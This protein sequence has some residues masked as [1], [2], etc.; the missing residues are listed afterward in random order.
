MGQ[1]PARPRHGDC[2]AARRPLVATDVAA[3]ARRRQLTHVI[4][5]DVPSAPAAY[6]HRIG[7]VGRA[8]REGVAI[9]LAQPREHRM[10]KQIERATKQPIAVEKVPTVADLRSRRLEL[11]R[12]GLEESLL[13]DELDHFRVVVETLAEEHDVMDIAAAA[14]KLAHELAA[15]R[16]TRTRSPTCRRP[17]SAP[18][19]AAA[20]ATA[21]TRARASRPAR[22]P[23]RT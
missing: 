22:A 20:T 16:S 6:V 11:T 2:A 4:N 19:T 13:E 14:V 8:G 10:L 21:R 7:R 23:A 1:Q 17:A 15:A 3:R 18:T 5:Y 12:A 9:T